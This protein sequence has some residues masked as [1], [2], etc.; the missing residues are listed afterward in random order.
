MC[1]EGNFHPCCTI[2]NQCLCTK[3]NRIMHYEA[4]TV[5]I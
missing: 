2:L 4:Y 3:Y 5:A 1:M